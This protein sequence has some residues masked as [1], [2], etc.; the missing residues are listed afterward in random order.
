MKIKTGVLIIVILI[1]GF[2]LYRYATSQVGNPTTTAK[3]V[4]TAV[5]SETTPTIIGNDFHTGTT[6]THNHIKPNSI[7]ITDGNKCP[8]SRYF[9]GKIIF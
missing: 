8:A 7:A 1:A 3:T 6:I 9:A 4:Q 5:V 2:L